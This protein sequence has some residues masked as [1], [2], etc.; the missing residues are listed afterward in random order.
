[1]KSFM[2]LDDDIKDWKNYIKILE[3]S[4]ICRD[5]IDKDDDGIH[6]NEIKFITDNLGWKEIVKALKTVKK[7]QKYYTIQ[8]HY[9]RF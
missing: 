6:I 4:D 8:S 7:T 2:K 3:L 9:G 5:I 1:M